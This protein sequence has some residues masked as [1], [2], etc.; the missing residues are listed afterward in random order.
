MPAPAALLLETA[1]ALAAVSATKMATTR[2]LVGAD[3]FIDEIVRV[4]DT[5]TDVNTWTPVRTIADYAKRLAAAAGKSTNV[6]LVLEQTK[7]GG[8]GPLM[9]D[10]LGALGTGITYVGAVG[11]GSL[12]PVFEPLRRHGDVHPIADPA[13]TIAA[14]FEDGKI[15]HGKLESLNEVTPANLVARLGGEEALDALLRNVELL[16]MVNWTMIPHLTDVW[17]VLAG[18]M[19]MLPVGV[20]PRLCFFDL[21]DPEKRTHADR[22][23]AMQ[24][25]ASF[26]ATGVTP[27][28]GLNE[29]ESA[30]ICAAMDVEYGTEDLAGMRAR[31]HRLIEATG[32]PEIVVHPR[33][34]AAAVGPDGEGE[35][36]GPYCANPKLTT[37]AGDHFNGGYAFARA[38]G[39]VPQHA[40]VVGKAVSGFYVRQGRGP[41]RDE[42]VAFLKK[43]AEGTLD[44]WQG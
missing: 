14:E 17:A 3:G 23:R 10:A 42:A 37:G 43:W 8:N 2:A 1:T 6:E 27:I 13:I 40:V 19:A 30:E 22:R 29:K 39:L 7:M 20:G 41:S 32:I 18:R 26:K 24:T 9:C 16:A 5:R 11:N 25:I 35:V 34:T 4:V 33:T 44:P 21:C 12:H 15:M 36:E 28:L 38:M 31:I